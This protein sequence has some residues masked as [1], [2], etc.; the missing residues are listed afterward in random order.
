MSKFDDAR[1]QR[2]ARFAEMERTSSAK[3]APPEKPVVAFALGMSPDDYAKFQA[4]VA[5]AEHRRLQQVDAQRRY[6]LKKKVP[7]S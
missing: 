6:R 4:L 3:P 7:Q 5:K 1:K 2:E